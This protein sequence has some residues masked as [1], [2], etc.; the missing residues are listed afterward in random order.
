MRTEKYEIPR[1]EAQPEHALPKEGLVRV[2]QLLASGAVPFGKSTLYKK[3]KE[4]TFPPL[5][6]LGPR[7]SAIDVSTFRDYLSDP[8]GWKLQ[9]GFHG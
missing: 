7:I 3:I 5:I 1:S 8:E 9:G 2:S 6:K 4:G